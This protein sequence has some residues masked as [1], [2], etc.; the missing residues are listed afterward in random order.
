MRP[1]ADLRS[2]TFDLPATPA[3]ELKVWAHQINPEG[4]S[5][6]LPARLEVRL[7]AETRQ[8]DM[9]Q[10]GGEALL[11]LNGAGCRVQV[12]LRESGPPSQ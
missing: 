8:W 1:V 7:G 9:S 3:R 12:A 5:E 10:S 4:H 6:P 2:V 11:P